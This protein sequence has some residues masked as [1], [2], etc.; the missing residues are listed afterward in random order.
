MSPKRKAKQ[1]GRK[2]LVCFT[3][4]DPT[5]QEEELLF[6]YIPIKPKRA[7]SSGAVKVI[8][9]QDGNQVEVPYE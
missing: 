6:R 1:L 5:T 9:E 7:K 2:R 3:V 8:V 4:K